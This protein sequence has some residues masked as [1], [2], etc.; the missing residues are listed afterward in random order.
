MPPI[1]PERFRAQRTRVRFSGPPPTPR[2]GQPFLHGPAPLAWL[3]AAAS[4]PGKSLHAG[5]ALWYAAGL[6]RSRSVP[7]SNISGLRFGLDRNAKY[8]ALG[9]LEGAGLIIVERKFGRA[10]IVT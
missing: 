5:V 9:W 8:R 3:E 6:T 2:K 4:L 1:D 7:L 10:P